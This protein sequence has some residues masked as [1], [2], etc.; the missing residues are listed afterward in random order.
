M[1]GYVAVTSVVLSAFVAFGLSWAADSDSG[2]GLTEAKATTIS[3]TG[4]PIE[5]IYAYGAT[6]WKWV[7]GV[8]SV[9]YIKSSV[10]TNSNVDGVALK[11]GW[12][13]VEAADGVYSWTSVD[14]LIDDAAEAGKTVTLHVVAGYQTPN[15]VFSE[16]AQGFYFVWGESWG[17]QICSVVVV[18]RP[19]DPI[20][21]QKWTAFIRAFG[22][23]YNSNPTVAGVKISGLNSVDEETLLPYRVNAPITNGATSCTGYNDVVDWQVDGYTRLLIESAWQQIARAFQAAFPSKALV[24]TMNMGGFPPID[25]NGVIFTPPPSAFGQDQQATLDIIAIGVAD[26]GSQFA[27]QNDGLLSSGSAWPTEA[28]YA[29]QIT[30][31]YQ[32]ISALGV[33]LP[34]ALNIAVSAKAEYLELY[35]SDLGKPSLQSAIATARGQ[36][37]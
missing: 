20:F 28:S 10:L 31:G 13:T 37:L 36:L 16:G 23:R 5:G 27:L 1:K 2:S 9:E 4:S 8:G 32:T 7:K 12:D 25:D 17:P 34:S 15:W 19:W 35:A 3:T 29:N 24:A 21:L 18:P 30:T 6:A 14:G 11:V 33:N 26:F 22:A